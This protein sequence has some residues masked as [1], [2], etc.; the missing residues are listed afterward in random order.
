MIQD[1]TFEFTSSPLQPL[2]PKDSNFSSKECLAINS[3]L[4]RLL[5]KGVLILFTANMYLM[6][7]FHLFLGNQRAM[8]FSD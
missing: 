4:Q 1:C 2:V 3:D 6:I 8:D 7:S 5:D